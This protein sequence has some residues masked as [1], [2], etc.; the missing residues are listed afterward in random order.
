MKKFIFDIQRFVEISDLTPGQIVIPA[1]ETLEIKK[2]GQ[3]ISFTALEEISALYKI[4]QDISYFVLDDSATA[5]VSIT[6]GGQNLSAELKLGEVVS[7]RPETGTFGLTDANSFAEVTFG[8]NG[9]GFKMA[10]SDTAVF[11]IP[12][13]IDGKIALNFPNEQKQA[14]SLTLSK[15]GQPFFENNVAIDGTIAIDPAK[16]EISLTKGTSLTVN[17]NLVL[18]DA[19]S[20]RLDGFKLL[21]C[22]LLG[23][24]VHRQNGWL[25]LGAVLICLAI[26]MIVVRAKIPAIDV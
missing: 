11:F 24:R 26:V 17:D 4:E 15:D 5:K 19:S 2:D 3:T 25:G 18:T 13:I 10:T 20:L 7:Y 22:R 1:G 23:R 8:K 6:I 14:M 16:Q 9:Y 12:K 21:C